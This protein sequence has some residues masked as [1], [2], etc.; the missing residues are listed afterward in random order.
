MRKLWLVGAIVLVVLL[1]ALWIRWR[2][3]PAEATSGSLP[4][5]TTAVTRRHIDPVPAISLQINRADDLMLY[6]GTPM[7]ISVRIVNHR[8]MMADAQQTSD[9]VYIQQLQATAGRGELP[10]KRVEGQIARMGLAPEVS[11]IHLGE[12]TEPWD[13][14]LH[15]SERLPDGTERPLAWATKVVQPPATRRLTLDAQT[16]ADLTFAIEPSVASQIAAGEY[17]VV[18]A[19]DVPAN[20]TVKSGTWTGQARSEPVKLIIQDKPP[21]LPSGDAEKLELHFANFFYAVA[22]FPEAARHAQAALAANPKSI[23]ADIV[24][25]ET[26]RAQGDLTG[27]LGAFQKATVE[28]YRQNPNSYEPPTL[29]LSRISDLREKLESADPKAASPR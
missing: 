21:R 11:S 27:A 12:D 19:L 14:F 18:A 29:L 17:E 13:S 25:G 10:K 22:N 6:R 24:L 28:F 16:S 23:S 5:V 26:K 20:G 8:A 1:A 3:K 4:P 15:L 7:V 9:R 2:K